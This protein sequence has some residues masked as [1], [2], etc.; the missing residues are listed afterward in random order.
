MTWIVWL[1]LLWML[2]WLWDELMKW[3]KMRKQ[4]KAWKH[5]VKRYKLIQRLWRGV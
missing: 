3:W 4:L 5:H 2:L 1:L